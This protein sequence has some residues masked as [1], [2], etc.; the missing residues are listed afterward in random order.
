MCPCKEIGTYLINE[1]LQDRY[2]DPIRLELVQYF[3]HY[4]DDYLYITCR[5]RE[6]KKNE[7]I[8][9]SISKEINLKE[10]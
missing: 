9:M 8:A 1:L 2:S 4:W 3:D 7:V 10:K 5:E 6:R